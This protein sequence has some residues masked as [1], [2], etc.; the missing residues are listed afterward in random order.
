M[1]LKNL[2]LVAP[3]MLLHAAAASAAAPA[4]KHPDLVILASASRFSLQRDVGL[5]EIFLNQAQ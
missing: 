5:L 3:L 4:A 2:A 1:Q